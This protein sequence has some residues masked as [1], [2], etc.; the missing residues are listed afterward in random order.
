MQIRPVEKKI[1]TEGRQWSEQFDGSE[2]RNCISRIDHPRSRDRIVGHP[3]RD[4]TSTTSSFFRENSSRLLET[5]SGKKRE[6]RKPRKISSR[7]P[8]RVTIYNHSRRYRREPFSKRESDIGECA[9][10]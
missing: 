3:R 6:M 4:L 5:P 2:T 9:S 10:F 1:A 7:S 8:L